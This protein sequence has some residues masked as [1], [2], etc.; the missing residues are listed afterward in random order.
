MKEI[1][2]GFAEKCFKHA[3]T[4]KIYLGNQPDKL[5][6]FTGPLKVHFCGDY[7]NLRAWPEIQIALISIE[8]AHLVEKVYHA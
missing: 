3:G 1:W 4:P 2:I 7:W 5:R 6:G 8:S